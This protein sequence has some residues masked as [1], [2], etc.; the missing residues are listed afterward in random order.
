MKIWKKIVVTGGAGTCG[1]KIITQLLA[2]DLCE[3]VVAIDNDEGQLFSK[4]RY[5]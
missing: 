5:A 4:R 2:R 3:Q 1:A